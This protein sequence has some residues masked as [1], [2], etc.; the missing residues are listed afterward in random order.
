[1]HFQLSNIINVEQFF[2]SFLQKKHFFLLSWLVK[3]TFMHNWSK[4]TGC[5]TNTAICISFGKAYAQ[6][7]ENTRFYR[8]KKNPAVWQFLVNTCSK[9]WYF[10]IKK[11]CCVIFYEKILHVCGRQ[12]VYG[13]CFIYD[14]NLK[15]LNLKKK[16]SSKVNTSDQASHSKNHLVLTHLLKEVWIKYCRTQK[17]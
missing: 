8:T 10:F 12:I 1:M 13:T 3:M 14:K 17:G 11:T 7:L 5:S 15:N 2:L 16:K 9:N 4:Q 6:L